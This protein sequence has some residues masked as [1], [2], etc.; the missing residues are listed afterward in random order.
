MWYHNFTSILQKSQQLFYFY[1]EYGIILQRGDIYSDAGTTQ[2]TSGNVTLKLLG[3]TLPHL[4]FGGSSAKEHIGG[5]LN[6]VLKGNTTINK[7]TA[8]F[9]NSKSYPAVIP[10]YILTGNPYDG[11]HV[12]KITVK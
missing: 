2:G 1:A 6:V 3:G 12:L 4:S 5:N 9:D 8:D 11:G 10:Q 7:L